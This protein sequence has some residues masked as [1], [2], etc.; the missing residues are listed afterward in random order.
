MSMPQLKNVSIR[1]KTHIEQFLYIGLFV[2][3]AAQSVPARDLG[4]VGRVYPVVE[5]SA[6]DEIKERAARVDWKKH[7]EKIKPENYRPERRVYLPRATKQT[8]RLVDMTYTLDM[9]IPDGKGGILYPRGYMFN[10][11]DYV[12]YPRTLVLIN[13]EDKGQVKWFSTSAYAHR[14]DVVLLI[15]D[16][17]FVDVTKKMQRPVYYADARIADKFK[18]KALPSVVKQSGRVMEVTEYVVKG[19]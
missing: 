14:F 18:I 2:L 3:F 9:D 17:A 16:G 15:T 5:R 12:S 19:H 4:T 8:V 1:F 7:L 13:A 6:V 10:P 11:L